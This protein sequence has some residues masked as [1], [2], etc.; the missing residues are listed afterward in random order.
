MQV[1][2]FANKFYT[3]WNVTEETRPL[4]NG[5]NY[6]ITHFNFIKNISFD[7]E[8]ALAKHPGAKLDESLRGRTL[9]FNTQKKVWDNVDTF[10]FGKYSGQK[11]EENNDLNYISWYWGSDISMDHKEF[12]GEVLKKHGYEIRDYKGCPG[13]YL[14]S[15]EALENERL[16][17]EA[18][19]KALTKAK[20]GETFEFVAEYSLNEF[21]EYR[22]DN[23]I[24][25]FPYKLNYYQGYEYGLPL[26]NGKAKRIKHKT[27]K[28]TGY[29]FEEN[30]RTIIIKV[31][32][33]EIV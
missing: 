7:K 30:E 11:I 19:E 18:Y 27:I 21:G 12:V 28:V 20:N 32:T 8:T 33:F 16:E 14:M 23:V 25:T 15:P 24:F 1:I 10:R 22:V 9:S 5:C 13:Q 2:G 3:L 29:D 17:Q 4:G 31:N 26:L 6:I